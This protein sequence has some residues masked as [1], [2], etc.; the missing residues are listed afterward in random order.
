MPGQGVEKANAIRRSGG[1]GDGQDD[2]KLAQRPLR[3]GVGTRAGCL[4]GGTGGTGRVAGCC[5]GD[6]R[7]RFGSGR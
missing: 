1:T 2:R 5:G 6:G 7:A 4:G 3:L